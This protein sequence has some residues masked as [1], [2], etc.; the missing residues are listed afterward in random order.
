[1]VQ[2]VLCLDYGERRIGV[3]ISDEAGI[4]AMPLCV[5]DVRDSGQTLREIAGICAE[6]KPAK[7][8]VGMPLNMN[9]SRGRKAEEAKKFAKLLE[10]GVGIPVETWDERLSSRQAER[11]LIGGNVSRRK[12]KGIVDKL[13]AQIVLQAYLDSR[14]GPA[15]EG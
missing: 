1:M 6:K 9:G 8:V 2:R 13:A 11:A 4:I 10:T 12:R 7:I 5:I 14:A 3:A 15:R